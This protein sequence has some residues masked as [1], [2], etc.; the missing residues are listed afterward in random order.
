MDHEV[1]TTS[2]EVPTPA[3][4]RTLPEFCGSAV[5]G[6]F[7]T[8][9]QL[10]S[11]KD[12]ELFP[13][14]TWVV[15]F[16]KSGTT[17]IQQIVRLIHARG[18]DDGGKISDVVP[19][20]EAASCFGSDVSISSLQR[21]R[22]FKSHFPYHHMPCGLPSETPCKY[23]FVA[24]NPKDVAVS[25]FHHYLS[26]KYVE[27]LCW[28]DFVSWFLSGKVSY[29]DYFEHVLSWWEH[30][31]DKN[32]LFLKYEDMKK[33][34]HSTIVQISQFLGY[35]LSHDLVEKIAKKSTFTSMK[36]DASVSYEWLDPGIPFIRKGVIGDWKNYFTPEQSK[37]FDVKYVEKF[38]PVGLELDFE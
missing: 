29:G 14:D 21:P 9:A 38:K 15:S 16:P 31:N 12:L 28:D 1:P 8:Q 27:N 30:R 2:T 3:G 18:E 17:W 36:T 33:D 6:R 32:V 13:D 34:L 20:L 22:A 5:A 4:V 7:V 23:I 26:F 24:R 35:N 10:D 25:F 19:C 37:W 11:L